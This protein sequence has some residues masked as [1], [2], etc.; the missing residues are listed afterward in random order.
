MD[1]GKLPTH[2]CPEERLEYKFF[3]AGMEPTE[4]CD[5]HNKITIPELIGFNI[6]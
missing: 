5:F 6:E 3:T 1:S 4:Y 2:W